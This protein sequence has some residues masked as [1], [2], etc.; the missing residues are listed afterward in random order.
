MATRKGR[1]KLSEAP[2]PEEELLPRELGVE[3]DYL[4]MDGPQTEVPPLETGPRLGALIVSARNARGWS[5]TVLSNITGLSQNTLAKYER[6]GEP[7]GK[8]PPA[9]KLATLCYHLQIDPREALKA[10]RPSILDM[11]SGTPTNP[12]EQMMGE[13]ITAHLEQGNPHWTNAADINALLRSL[14]LQSRHQLQ[15]LMA[16]VRAFKSELKKSGPDQ[17]DQSRSLE[18]HEPQKLRPAPTGKSPKRS[19]KRKPPK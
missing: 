11:R 19:R 2:P 12:N 16:E 18:N 4:E 14:Y 3:P 8:M 6:A 5:R 13:F 10:A 7:G 9:N 17:S 15:E 1:K